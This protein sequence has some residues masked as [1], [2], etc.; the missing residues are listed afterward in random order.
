MQDMM[1]QDINALRTSFRT[2]FTQSHADSWLDFSDAVTAISQLPFPDVTLEQ[3]VALRENI[4]SLFGI[5]LSPL[6]VDPD[7][8]PSDPDANFVCPEP[9]RSQIL[10]AGSLSRPITLGNKT[11]MVYIQEN[12]ITP[13]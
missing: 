7:E 13:F 2:V 8:T 5:N 10:T 3:W 12:M 6:L 4:V 9:F 1:V 11:V